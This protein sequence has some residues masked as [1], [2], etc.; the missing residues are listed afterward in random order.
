MAMHAMPGTS[1]TLP[2]YFPPR[3]CACSILKAGK[4]LPGKILLNLT[5]DGD[6]TDAG[7]S[8]APMTALLGGE[9]AGIIE[10]SA[11]V[12]PSTNG[13]HPNGLNS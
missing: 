4:N 10:A 5:S 7:G 8:G 9:R 11:A 2:P 3:R 6:S 1:S 13:E 12:K